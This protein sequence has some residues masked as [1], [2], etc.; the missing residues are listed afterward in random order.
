M[1]QLVNE[2][3]E[4]MRYSKRKCGIFSLLLLLWIMALAMPV[5]AQNNATTIQ[6]NKNSVVLYI[7]GIKTINLKATVKGEASKIT[8]VSSNKKV[9]DVNSKGK[10]TAKKAGTAII[11]ARVNGKTARCKVTVKK[12]KVTKKD[13]YGLYKKYLLQNES[14]YISMGAEN[15]KE[16]YKKASGFLTADLDKDGI[17]E[18]IT[19]HPVGWRH[20]QLY[21]FTC[22]NGKVTKIKNSTSDSS[23]DMSSAANGSYEVFACNRNHLHTVWSGVNALNFSSASNEKIYTIEKEKLK[24]YAAVS[25]NMSRSNQIIYEVNGSQVGKRQY[26]SVVGKCKK[27][28]YMYSNNAVNRSKYLK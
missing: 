26:E 14:K 1:V 25:D 10:V 16:S 27:I 11:T 3:A 20:D 17:P 22:K 18:L 21:V 19:L 5:Y 8:W 12:S 7:S 2:R 9:A 6:L 24:C 23:I 28:A 13:I 4:V 15:N